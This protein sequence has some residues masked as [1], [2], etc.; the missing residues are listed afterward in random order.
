MSLR[1]CS[2]EGK[3]LPMKI[4]NSSR[5]EAGAGAVERDEGA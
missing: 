3:A 2:I 1:D 5:G 4:V